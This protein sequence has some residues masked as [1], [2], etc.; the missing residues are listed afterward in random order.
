MRPTFFSSKI[1]SSLRRAFARGVDAK[2]TST[3]SLALDDAT[4]LSVRCARDR[5]PLVTVETIRYACDVCIWFFKIVDCCV[6]F[7]LSLSVFAFR[8]RERSSSAS[9]TRV[10]D[11][12]FHV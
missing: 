4:A 9:T 12:F 7:F 3:E 11:C 10:C 2:T 6:L 8:R 5:A 1:V